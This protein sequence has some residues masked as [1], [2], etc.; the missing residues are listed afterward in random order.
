MNTPAK[1][2]VRALRGQWHGESGMACCPVHAD[3]VPSLS[4]SDQGHKVLIHC[5]AGCHQKAVVSALYRL[6]LWPTAN[7]PASERVEVTADHKAEVNTDRPKNNHADKTWLAASQA[8]GTLAERYLRNRGIH[9]PM[10]PSLRFM[11]SLLHAPT[12]QC[13]P[14]VVAAVH[15]ESGDLSAIQRVFIRPDG[16]G[17]AQVTPAKMSLGPL[18]DGAVRLAP[19]GEVIGLC[20]GWETGLSAMQL[21]D[22]PVWC[23]LGAARMHCVALPA[24]VRKIVIFADNDA[25][26]R[27][28]AERTAHVQRHHGRSVEIRLPA[29]GADFNDELM[30]AGQS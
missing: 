26:G 8:E 29:I 20:E 1:Q 12:G 15:A 21:Y 28:A 19:V 18:G 27:E 5:H 16:L 23:A 7:L 3:R 6:G 10:P 14:V 24:G 22:L 2:I 4:V 17:K 30:L 11:P 25:A 9:V 13:L